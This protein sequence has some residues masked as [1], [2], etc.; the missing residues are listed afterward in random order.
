MAKL[1]TLSPEQEKLM[2]VVCDRSI[3][4]ALFNA[5]EID[6]VKAHESINW[7]YEKA[8]KVAPKY[9]LHVSS[10]LGL[11]YAANLMKAPGD[12]VRDQ[13][14]AQVGAQVWDQVRDQVWAQVGA[15]V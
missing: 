7:L 12:Q 8:G 5:P 6:V 4:R 11:Q 10:P 3:D 15:Q 1:E 14:W 13:V 2:A 9:F